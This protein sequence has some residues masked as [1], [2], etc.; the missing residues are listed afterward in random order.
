MIKVIKRLQRT[1]NFR[2]IQVLPHSTLSSRLKWLVEMETILDKP[3]ILDLGASA[4]FLQSVLQLWPFPPF[5][6]KEK[7]L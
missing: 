4:H 6:P 2:S 7:Y 5:H 1:L 3:L